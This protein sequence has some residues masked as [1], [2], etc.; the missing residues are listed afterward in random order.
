MT[1]MTIRQHEEERERAELAPYACLSA[2]SRGRK[3]EE[4]PCD[5]RTCF[6]RDRD[7][8]LHSK[9]FRRL[10]HKTQVFIAPEG[11]H[12]RTRLT[13]TLEV[14]GI[15]R[16]IARALRLNEDLCEAIAMGHDLGHTPFGH[17]GERELAHLTE[18]KFS[19]N[20]QSV[21]VAEKIERAGRGLNLTYEV[22]DGIACHSGEAKSE[23]L[24]GQVV[25]LS[26]RIAYINHDIDDACRG[27]MLRE[28]DIPGEYKDILGH[29]HSRRINTL[30]LDTISASMGK[31]EICMSDEVYNAMMG[32]RR[33]M[34]ERVYRADYALR[35]EEK[36][37]GMIAKLFEYY[38]ADIDRM[39]GEY[40]D[41]AERDGVTSAVC[42]YIACMTDRYALNVYS[43]LFL[44]ISWTGI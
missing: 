2:N 35:Q 1:K 30:V 29:R 13:H 18:G 5:I 32:L 22:L 24:E 37:R 41:I 9:S 36:V 6:I 14:S 40:R 27:G 43:E 10:K 26:D 7:R 21:R 42:D 4:E 38:S 34:F 28:S 31:N 44:P 8:I 23:T 25:A 19:H 20:M 39:P 17:G 11:D 12:Y 15:A 33:F 3:R 16:T